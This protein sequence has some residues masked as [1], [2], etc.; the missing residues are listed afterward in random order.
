MRLLRK[1]NCTKIA[2]A[3]FL[4]SL[5]L[6]AFFASADFA[7]STNFK[8]ESGVVNSGGGSATSTSYNLENSLGQA[9]VGVSTSTSFILKG[10]FLNFP[11]VVATTAPTS[12][13]PP[14]IVPTPAPSVGI[15]SSGGFI[16]PPG[17]L[18]TPLPPCG[19]E[20]PD[21]NCDS[22]VNLIDLSILLYYYNQ[23]GPAIARY[24]F[25]GDGVVDFRDVSV[26]MFYWTA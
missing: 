12:A 9:G 2:L 6:R 19:A 26:L 20:S 17:V 4:S 7:T 22:R 21:L 8:L 3:I 14:V 16:P 11:A 13:P 23:R 10:G 1:Q 15:G 25:A 18:P 5:A 24:D